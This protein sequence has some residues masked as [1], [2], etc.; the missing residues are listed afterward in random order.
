M[1]APLRPVHE[2]GRLEALARYDLLDTGAEQSLD[3][4][5]ALAAHICGTP[6]STIALID[7]HRQWYKSRAGDFVMTE[8]PRDVSFCGHAILQDDVFIVSDATLDERFADNP[9][10]TADPNIR[11]YA[12]VPLVTG[13]GHALGAFCVIDRE[14]RKL[15]AAQLDA[16]RVLGRQAMAQMELRRTSR[17]VAESEA[18]LQLV[19]ENARVG[20]VM[21]NEDRRYVYANGT[22]AD[23]FELPSPDIIGQRV[24]DVLPALYE[25]QIRP[26][27]DRAFTGERIA[28]EVRRSR[29]DGE[30]Y[31][32]VRCEPRVKDGR[33]ELVVV[34][35]TEITASKRADSDSR[36]L[37]AIVESSEDAIIGKDLDG[38]VS[39]WNRG[40]ERIFGYTA[41][42]MVG[43]SIMRIIPS[44]R[45]DEEVHILAK[46][47]NGQPLEHF[48]TVRR[49]KDGREIDVSITTSPIRDAAGIVVGASKVARDITDR[50]HTEL[51][52]RHAAE[53]SAVAVQEFRALFAVNPLT[54]W[55]YDVETLQFLEVNEAAVAQYGYSR[56]EF[57]AM[58]IKDIRESEDVERLI[59]SV[60]RP[61]AAWA[62]AGNWRHRL[63]S[64]RIID[65]D[66]TSHVIAFDGRSAALVVANDV[67]ARTQALE[68]QRASEERYRNL[69]DTAPDGI[70]VVDRNNRFVDANTSICRMLGYDREEFVGLRTENLLV[71]EERSL[72]AAARAA[73]GT[74]PYM[75]EW[76]FFRKDGSILTA[77]SRAVRMPGGE[78]LAVIRDVTERNAAVEALRIAEERMRFALENAGL[79]IWENDF[80]TSTLTWSPILE[81]HHGLAPGTFPGTLEAFHAAVHPDDRAGALETVARAIATGS[82]FP[83]L[84][85]VVWPDGTIRWLT[86][87]GRIVH[88]EQGQPLRGVGVLMDITE[89]R[90]LEAQFQQAQKMEAIGRLA[91]GVAHDFNNVLTAILG[92]CELLLADTDPKD[93]RFADLTEIGKAGMRAASLTRQLL[94]FSRKQVIAPTRLDLNEIVSDVHSML[95]RLIGED[96]DIRLRLHRQPGTVLVDRGQMDQVIM[97]LAVNARDAMPNGGTLTIETTNVELDEN[98]P[99]THLDVKPGPY[100]LLL[101][102][103]TGSGMTAEVQARL[104]EPFFTTKEV[105]KGTGLGLATVHG[106]VKGNGGSINVYSELGLGTTFKIYLPR[107][108]YVEPGAQPAASTPRR[109]AE[110]VLVVDDVQALRDL[111]KRLLERLGY[112]VLTA[113]NAEEAQAIF[114]GAASIDVLL[115]D[116]VMP[117][118]S[119]PELTRRLAQQ[120]PDLRVIYM[121]GYTEETMA[122]HGVLEPGIAF[123]HKPFSSDML[124]RKLREVLDLER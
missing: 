22:Y 9:L 68:A 76:H 3:D 53:R 32:A 12:G 120:R 105:G 34:V 8:T 29:A 99:K 82:D 111:T 17:E 36:R 19:T 79:G 26:R 86:G 54:M 102:T 56:E 14:P 93:E 50:K 39:S 13:D 18:R 73:V 67:T 42:E 52:L 90:S 89:R 97:N 33:V 63:K 72:L 84:H 41:G 83:I 91:G 109:G 94:A 116:V 35:I 60:K 47:R 20:L 81:A 37:A 6:V 49:T 101:V 103:D 96:V 119:G 74:T 10:V 11:F 15:T 122:H 117:G 92:Y 7:E 95:E 59:A 21:L 25:S 30:V 55:I 71:P 118:A 106:I 112:T 78:T 40:A 98:Y 58:T 77:E 100:V 44:D 66:I 123:V 113:A 48:E 87:A 114:D 24:A 46:V 45:R 70:I 124:A 115:T 62:P 16:L 107:V 104:F 61:R 80:R 85:R 88:D 5:T 75:R 38:V 23:I 121:S 64:G 57:L 31:Y 51:Q 2:R 27:L 4:L 43:T 1:K 108:D 65:V 110:T 69:F 28:Y